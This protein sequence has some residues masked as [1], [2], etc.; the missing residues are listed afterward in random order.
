MPESVGKATTVQDE[1]AKTM[2]V[3]GMQ[4]SA[5]FLRVKVKAGKGK[6]TSKPQGRRALRAQELA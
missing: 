2:K 4:S 3:Q 5:G 6:Q 1:Q